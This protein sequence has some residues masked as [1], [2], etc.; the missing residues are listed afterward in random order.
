MVLFFNS[1]Q[2]EEMKALL[3]TLILVLI[4]FTVTVRA[5][6]YDTL[7]IIESDDLVR[8]SVVSI[9]MDSLDILLRFDSMAVMTAPPLDSALLGEI[10]RDTNRVIDTKWEIYWNTIHQTQQLD[11]IIVL[12][13]HLVEANPTWLKKPDTLHPRMTHSERWDAAMRSGYEAGEL[14]E[15][16]GTE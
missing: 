8:D 1:G 10:P 3:L 11:S 5:G 12:L 7:Y 2:G 9:D 13:K 6:I 4:P 15:G 16:G 14:L